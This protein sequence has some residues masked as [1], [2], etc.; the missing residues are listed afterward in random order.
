MDNLYSGYWAFLAE[1]TRAA[2]KWACEQLF[3]QHPQR[4]A[5]VWC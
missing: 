2:D 5:L 4:G 1:E 3:G